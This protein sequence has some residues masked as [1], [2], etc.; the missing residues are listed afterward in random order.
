MGNNFLQ[1]KLWLVCETKLVSVYKTVEKIVAA[2][3]KSCTECVRSITVFAV[4]AVVVRNAI[5][6]KV[7]IENCN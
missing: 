4:S 2:V 3:K 1:L 7:A 5:E 6:M